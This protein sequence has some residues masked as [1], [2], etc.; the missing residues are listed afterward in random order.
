MHFQAWLVLLA[1]VSTHGQDP[2]VVDL[3]TTGQWVDTGIDVHSGD[4][5]GVTLNARRANAPFRRQRNSPPVAGTPGSETLQNTVPAAP[6]L[7]GRIGTVAFVV[8][9]NGVAPAT[10]RL[11]LRINYSASSYGGEPAMVRARISY[12]S[13]AVPSPNVVE[14]KFPTRNRTVAV[15][16]PKPVESAFVPLPN[17]VGMKF[18][19]AARSLREYGLVPRRQKRSS[20]RPAGEVVDQSPAPDID[21]NTVKSVTLGVSDGSLAQTSAVALKTATPVRIGRSSSRTPGEVVQPRPVHTV[22]LAPS[23]VIHE[24]STPFRIQPAP[25]IGR[26]TPPHR[27]VTPQPIKRATP[28]PSPTAPPSPR[29]TAPP[30]RRAMPAATSSVTAAPT[31]R[32]TATS[33]GRAAAKAAPPPIAPLPRI[34]VP[35]VV[36]FTQQDAAAT[37]RRANLRAVYRGAEL[38]RLEAGRITRTDPAAGA[39]L[40]RGSLVGYWVANGQNVVP[41]NI[42]AA[43]QASRNGWILWV[44]AGALTLVAVLAGLSINNR[45]RLAKVTRSLLTVRPSLERDG[46][47]SF[48]SDVTMA[49]PA[50]HVRASVELGEVSFEDGSAIAMRK[51][52]DD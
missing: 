29:V 17:V 44:V 31:S 14:T 11:F 16:T 8:S 28:Q 10:G 23:P 52:H 4:S 39:G 27:H 51:E 6:T 15:K 48:A 35:L 50:T 19:A 13:R 30:T 25:P 36:G 9:A 12:V 24:S 20:S 2:T 37:L 45:M 5:L 38:S 21:T 3:P 33:R 1:L 49:G 43:T 46:P 22:Y 32:I 42:T 47:T 7:T 26:A 41:R 34:A 40:Q 18:G